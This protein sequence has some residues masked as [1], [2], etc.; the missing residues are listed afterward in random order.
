[1][2]SMVK[3]GL[4]PRLGADVVPV[5]VEAAAEETEARLLRGLHQACPGLSGRLGL[6]DAAAA[7][8]RGRVLPAAGK[9][10][11]VLDQFEQWLHAGQVEDAPELIGALRQC[12]GEHVQA[13]V[14][15][16]DDFWMA[17]TRFVRELEVRILDGDNSGAVDLFDLRHARRVLMAF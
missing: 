9:V 13:L 2:T 6:V 4:L 17:V 15:V 16:R 7:V 8:R 5:Y 1:K 12:D 11:L 14:L 3:A 10:L